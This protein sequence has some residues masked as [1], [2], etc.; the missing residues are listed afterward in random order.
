MT[1]SNLVGCCDRQVGRLLALED[2]AGVDAD[3]TI[4]IRDAG[5]VAHQAAGLDELAILIDRGQ[6]MA[7]RQCDELFAPAVEEADRGR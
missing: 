4:R 3:L 1:S 2:A 6:R 5:S 7:S